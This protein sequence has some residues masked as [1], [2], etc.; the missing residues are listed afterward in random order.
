MATLDAFR[1]YAT[2]LAVGL[3]GATRVLDAFHV[4]RV[5]REA[6][7]VQVGCKD[8]PLVC[9]SRPVELRAA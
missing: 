8:P 7:C 6:P 9:R 1:G 4:V 2:A 5:R 3:P